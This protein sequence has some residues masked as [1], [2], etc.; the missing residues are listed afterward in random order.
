MRA[1][2]WTGMAA[3][4]L[5]A[6]LLV[7]TAS[8]QSP[9]TSPVW[10][11]GV[12]P[13]PLTTRP[14][15]PVWQ[16]L[17]GVS[18]ASRVTAQTVDELG[19]QSVS[20]VTIDSGRSS[21]NGGVEPVYPAPGQFVRR[22]TNT[23]LTSRPLL[24][25][26]T[27]G[28]TTKF[29]PAAGSVQPG[30]ISMPMHYVTQN[31]QSVTVNAGAVPLSSSSP[32]LLTYPVTPPVVTSTPVMQPVR[33]AGPM[34]A[35]AYRLRTLLTTGRIRSLWSPAPT[36]VESPTAPTAGRQPSTG[37]TTV[38]REPGLPFNPAI[39]VSRALHQN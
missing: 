32:P 15:P 31:P 14:E 21:Q 13:A 5:A 7:G 24:S 22:S 9:A 23:V 26:T 10:D 18:T 38:R 34:E 33:R 4:V 37:A 27:A 25:G 30:G 3:G 17:P 20:K 11:Q 1:L 12:G 19:W 2:T 36:I 39:P 16:P 28:T 6:S 8:G 35:T 29:E